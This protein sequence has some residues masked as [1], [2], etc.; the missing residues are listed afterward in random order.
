MDHLI[1]WL[2]RV[3][4]VFIEWVWGMQRAVDLRV[5]WPNCKVLNDTLDGARDEFA[6]YAY[7]EP[8]WV[9]HYGERR[10]TEFIEGLT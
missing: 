1:V 4:R 10:L 7:Y 9:E 6:A 8:C 5:F 2:H 3:G